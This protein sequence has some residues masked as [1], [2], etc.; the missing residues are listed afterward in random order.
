M[1]EVI[2][3]GASGYIGSHLIKK[4]K[5]KKFDVVGFSRSKK[6]N[7]I[8]I[9]N[10]QE[11]PSSKYLIYLSE[12]SNISIFNKLNKKKVEKNQK[13]ISKLSKKYKTNFIY[14]S[15]SK[16]YSD[17]LKKKL[18][19]KDKITISSNYEKNKV[20]CE[21]IVLKNKGVVLRISN[22]YGNHIKKES[23]FKTILK[24][25]NNNSKVIKLLNTNSVRDYL[26]IDDLID[27]IAIIL[28][29]PVPGIFNVGTG[30][31]TSIIEL[32]KV[33]FKIYKKKK[34]IKV[35]NK[36]YKFSSQILDISKTS[37]TYNWKPRY[38]ILTKLRKVIKNYG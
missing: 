14:T 5:K 17:K 21:K 29:R 7:L 19:E 28:K 36:D 22:I 20:V 30:T 37:K 15:S 34:P 9:K 16:V 31:G 38:K 32:L 6:K 26:F 2:V 12:E 24:Q 23:V 13:I 35:I 8:K 25:L 11:L 33:I 1:I 27:L 4:L 3:T 18:D 10:Y